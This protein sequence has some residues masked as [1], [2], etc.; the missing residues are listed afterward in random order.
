MPPDASFMYGTDDYFAFVESF[1]PLVTRNPQPQTP[2]GPGAHDKLLEERESL[3]LP[4]PNSVIWLDCV[5]S[6]YFMQL[7]WRSDP[8]R[9]GNPNDSARRRENLQLLDRKKFLVGILFMDTRGAA[10]SAAATA[11]ANAAWHRVTLLLTSAGVPIMTA[12]DFDLNANDG[13]QLRYLRYQALCTPTE[14]K[15]L[16]NVFSL[17]FLPDAKLHYRDRGTPRTPPAKPK[18]PETSTN[19]SKHVPIQEILYAEAEEE[20]HQD[21]PLVHHQSLKVF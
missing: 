8:C 12:P 13:P 1:D 11:F 2:R 7:P 4:R 15:S 21:Q 18:P 3:G 14:R 20:Q 9:I 10:E 6:R 17:D 5:H 16:T 19:M